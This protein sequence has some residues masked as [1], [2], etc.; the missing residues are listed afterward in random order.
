MPSVDSEIGSAEMATA[1][2]LVSLLTSAEDTV[3]GGHLYNRRMVGQAA[4][5]GVLMETVRLSRNFDL[6]SVRGQVVVD[7]LVASAVSAALPGGDHPPLTALV[8]QVA[9]GVAGARRLRRAQRLA[10]LAFYRRCD[11]VIAASPYLGEELVAAGIPER[12]ITIVEPG[13]NLTRGPSSSSVD[14]R[15]GRK[16]AVLNVANWLP[17]KGIIDLLD[18]VDRIPTDEV[19]LHLVG[20]PELDA[21]YS[22]AIR[23]RLEDPVLR[24]K[25]VTHGALPQ[26]QLVELYTGADVLVLTSRDEGYATVIAEALGLGV[27]VIA[28]LSGN[29][30]NLF[31]DGTEGFQIRAGDVSRLTDIIRRLARDEELR[32]TLSS[33]AAI[34]GAKL[35]TWEQ[36][37][38]LFFAALE[39]VGS[40]RR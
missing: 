37:A 13:H 11:L 36:S 23:S 35:P 20:S 2:R 7:S 39:E 5:H 22:I 24:G 32:S 1:G 33:N 18:A 16:L 14:M 17:N 9:G 6:R 10:D 38:A 3:T 28:W 12:R 25:V 31:E 40:A 4:R 26:G 34:R 30:A 27:P 15:A 19:V 29:V 21:R 8:H